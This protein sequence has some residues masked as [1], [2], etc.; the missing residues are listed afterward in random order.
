MNNP[1]E[2]TKIIK[3][4]PKKGIMFRDV[5]TILRDNKL[6]NQSI[7]LLLD[8]I[9]PLKFDIIVGIESRGFIFGSVL[10]M[11]RYVGFVPARKKG[12]LPRK[13]ISQ[14]Y[15][16]EYGEAEI[17]INPEDIKGKRVL[18]VD[19][20]LATGGTAEAVCKLVK[21]S[22]AKVVGCLFVLEI[23]ALKGS[24]KLKKYKV[25]SGLKV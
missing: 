8:K 14:K 3:D 20:V 23:V 15:L 13:T 2:K 9:A 4:F 24:K 21:R 18:I 7:H 5:T 17:E 19:D 6:F 16:L 10:A 12:K 1:L 11:D 22:G 25:I